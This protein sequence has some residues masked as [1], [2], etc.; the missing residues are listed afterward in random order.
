MFLCI[1]IHPLHVIL[2]PEAGIQAV[3]QNR[4]VNGFSGQARGQGEGRVGLI[5]VSTSW[6]L[7]HFHGSG[8]TDS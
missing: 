8:F 7:S 5:T 2:A 4:D 3:H 6:H 1:S